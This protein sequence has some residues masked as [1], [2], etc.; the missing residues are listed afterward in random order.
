M[1]LSTKLFLGISGVMAA[2]LLIFGYFILSVDFKKNLDYQIDNGIKEFHSSALLISQSY[3]TLT[4]NLD[5]Q[6]AIILAAQYA[7]RSNHEHINLYKDTGEPVLLGISYTIPGEYLDGASANQ[8]KSFTTGGRTIVVFTG[9]IDTGDQKFI[10]QTAKD[11]TGVY[12]NFE[13]LRNSFII[14]LAVSLALSIVIAYVF[15]KSISARVEHVRKTSE[16]MAAGDYKK[17]ITITSN[18][19]FADMAASYNKMAD[20]IEEKISE[21]ENSVREKDDFIA[22]FSHEMKTPM[23][24]IVGYAD[25]IYHSQTEDQE[26]KEASN[27]ILNE[28][29]RLEKLSFN[30]L[31]LIAADSTKI[32]KESIPAEELFDDLKHVYS[33]ANQD[34]TITFECDQEYITVEYDL[35]KTVLT[36]LIDNA[37]KSNT[38]LV[39]VSGKKA[40]EGFTFSVTDHG[41][42]IPEA[43]LKKVTEAF[44]MVDKS[45]SRKAHGAGIGLALCDRIVKLHNSQLDIQ[46]KLNEGTTVSFTIAE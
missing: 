4:A 12:E 46:S 17:R 11:V 20:T 8:Y 5:Q 23:T 19:E 40:G 38:E 25:M 22:A 42:G 30:L 27:Y 21:L 39:E 15:S 28:G 9:I 31:N 10:L 43:D 34:V 7:D 6:S 32:T 33:S 18:D 24:S 14:I 29:L 37:L 36:N 3:G 44:Y 16:A 41:M 1:K 2:A 35:I 26:I 13:S 45:R